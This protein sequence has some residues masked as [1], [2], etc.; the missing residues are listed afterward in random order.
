MR[1]S[2]LART[3]RLQQSSQLNCRVGRVIAVPRL[4]RERRLASLD[5]LDDIPPVH[6]QAEAFATPK[7]RR[8]MALE[9]GA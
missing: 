5:M 1:Y 2:R 8:V 4:I 7:T 6:I 3:V 9:V